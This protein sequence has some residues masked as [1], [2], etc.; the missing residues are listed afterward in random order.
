MPDERTIFPNR[1]NEV[2][3]GLH[4][5]NHRVSVL[6]ETHK[7]TPYRLTKL[8]QLAEDMPRIRQELREQGDMIRK[9][10]TLTNGILC[11]AASMWFVFQAGPQFLKFL[12]SN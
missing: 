1:I 5:L 6:E 7:E 9:G 4:T 12:G 8:E 10:F 2:E 3:R 11:G